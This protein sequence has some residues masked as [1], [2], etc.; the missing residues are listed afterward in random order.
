MPP[1]ADPCPDRTADALRALPAVHELIATPALSAWHGRVPRSWIVA[2]ARDVLCE[3]RRALR[4]GHDGG[5]SGPQAD[6]AEDVARRL[7]RRARPNVRPVL[8]ATGILLHTG[9]GRAPLASAAVDAIVAVASGYASL[10][11]DLETGQRGQ[12]VDALRDLLCRLTGAESATVVNNNAAATLLVLAAL[13]AD[14]RRRV[15]VSR[16]ELIEIGGSFRLPPI[17]AASGAVL[18]EVGTTNKT[19]GADYEDAI[20]AGTAALLKVHAS[21]YRVIG[22]TQSVSIADLVP[23]GRR[24]GVPVLHDTGSGLLGPAGAGDEPGAS[25]SI[26]AGAD[27]VFF[28]GDKLLGGPQAG[29]IVGRRHWIDRIERHPLMRALRIDKL[30]LAGLEA[31]L[32]LHADPEMAG[33]QLPVRAMAAATAADLRVRAESVAAAL[34]TAET[35][36]EVAVVPSTAFLGGGALPAHGLDSIA[37][38]VRPATCGET[39]LAAR[40][41]HGRP[42]VIARVQEGAVWLDLRTVEPARD[43]DLITA[44]RSACAFVAD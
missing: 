4:A 24:H 9:L 18:V 8:N 2:A 31:T 28:S 12:R 30:T 6:P 32:R 33:R 3:R 14:E 15:I 22:F 36:A 16:G 39:T 13:T 35:G 10:E 25:A 5:T 17:M 38:R 37:L 26:A 11:L 1:P 41:R 21:N 42:P 29:V 43:A 7:A 27:L 23:I 40:L 19:R 34:G 44:L 20:D